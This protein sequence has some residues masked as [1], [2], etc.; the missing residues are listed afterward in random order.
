[1]YWIQRLQLFVK[2]V[3]YFKPHIKLFGTCFGHQL[4]CKTMLGLSVKRIKCEIGV[5]PVTL[6]SAFVDEFNTAT[7]SKPPNPMRIQLVHEDHVMPP[8]GGILPLN[9]RQECQL[10]NTRGLFATKTADISRPP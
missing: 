2:T 6:S 4:L 3:W 9:C 7:S 10:S 5:P 1:M 8:S